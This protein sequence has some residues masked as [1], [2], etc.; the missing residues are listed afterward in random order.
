[1][2]SALISEQARTPVRSHCKRLNFECELAH[3]DFLLDFTG[4]LR[5]A[6]R[7]L[8]ISQP[9]LHQL[10]DPIANAA[11]PIV[12]FERRSRKKAASGEDFLLAV[13]QPVL[14]E[15]SKALESLEFIRRAD[16][17]LDEDVAGRVDYR[18]LQ[19][20]FGA[21]VGEETAFADSESRSQLP[22]RQS[23]KPFERGKVDRLSE[24][25]P[26]GFQTS[27]PAEWILQRRAS[28]S[29]APTRGPS[30]LLAWLHFDIDNSTI[31]RSITI[32]PAKGGVTSMQSSF[33]RRA[34]TV[35]LYVSAGA[36]Y[37]GNKALSSAPFATT[38]HEPSPLRLKG[39]QGLLD[40]RFGSLEGVC[41]EGVK[42]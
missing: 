36:V 11:G 40:Y 4:E 27:R 18:A 37:F 26:A 19:I 8:Q 41:R 35:A 13:R 24:D 12:E 7:L 22:D 28:P 34:A 6:R 30:S 39:L 15:R 5:L 31:V 3:V 29:L 2:E 1:M 32:F 10:H 14:A 33:K 21:E 23:F 42:W 9:L 38:L 25:C 17:F 16:H 20:F